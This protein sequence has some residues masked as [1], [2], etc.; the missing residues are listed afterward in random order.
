[1]DS[2]VSKKKNNNLEQV[3]NFKKEPPNE[4]II[5]FVKKQNRNVSFLVVSFFSLL[6]I[7]S[8]NWQSS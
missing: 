3:Y 5:G 6:I 8:S 4:Y 1:M 2:T 7:I